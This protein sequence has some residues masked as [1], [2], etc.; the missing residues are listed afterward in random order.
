MFLCDD[1][2]VRSRCNLE[3]V[4]VEASESRIALASSKFD[5][6][7]SNL[8]GLILCGMVEEPVEPAGGFCLK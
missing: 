3:E 6:A 1:E 7:F 2:S 8:I 5:S 4:S